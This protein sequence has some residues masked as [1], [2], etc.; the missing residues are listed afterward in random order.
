MQ[1]LVDNY[2]TVF[3]SVTEAS[4][5][6]ELWGVNYSSAL[7]VTWLEFRAAWQQED[8][9]LTWTV[10]RDFGNYRFIVERSLDGSHFTPVD[11]IPGYLKPNAWPIP[12]WILTGAATR[13][14]AVLSGS[15]R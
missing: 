13:R 3:A 4:L 12:R 11:E 15:S 7:P 9:L 14:G 5:G 1:E 6:K 10:D 2:A 8:V